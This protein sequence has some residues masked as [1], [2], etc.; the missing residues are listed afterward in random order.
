MSMTLSDEIIKIIPKHTTYWDKE[1]KGFCV[2]R[3]FSDIITFSIYY[4]TATGIQRLQKIGRFGI[5]TCKQARQEAIRIS[6]AVCLG[7]DPSGEQKEK[8]KEYVKKRAK[9]IER[10]PS[11]TM[12]IGPRIG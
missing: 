7:M 8:R 11:C 3:Q 12:G 9:N 5:F 1:I 6:R 10:Y 2:R 4:R